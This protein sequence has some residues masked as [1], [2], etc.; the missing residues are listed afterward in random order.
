MIRCINGTTTHE[1]QLKLVFNDIIEHNGRKTTIRY[2]ATFC[3]YC[4]KTFLDP[5]QE[6][7]HQSAVHEAVSKVGGTR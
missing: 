5:Q 2:S 7:D 3:I 4:E 6:A 1:S